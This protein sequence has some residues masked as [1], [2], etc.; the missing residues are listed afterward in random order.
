MC[1]CACGFIFWLS[2]VLAA[3]Y[4]SRR[5]RSSN[6]STVAVRSTAI[7]SVNILWVV[8]IL[9]FAALVD[10]VAVGLLFL[11]CFRSC[12]LSIAL[13]V[14]QALARTPWFFF[15]PV[16]QKCKFALQV[17]GAAM[18]RHGMVSRPLCS[19]LGRLGC[20]PE[21]FCPRPAGL[22]V[23]KDTA[24]PRVTSLMPGVCQRS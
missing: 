12:S 23:V 15:F 6:S 5:R 10:I 20:S 3:T 7:A 19:N 13:K 4:K 22:E 16:L 17:Q 24:S 14:R 2:R 8:V 1:V 18:A 11:F 9:S 21:S